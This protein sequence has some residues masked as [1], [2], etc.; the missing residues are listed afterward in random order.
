MF[1]HVS[2]IL[3]KG[4]SGR[5]PSPHP[6]GRQTTPMADRHPLLGGRPPSGQTPSQ[7]WPLQQMVRIL[8]ECILV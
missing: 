3:S 6:P 2:V 4:G 8:L 1:L 5:H 7:G